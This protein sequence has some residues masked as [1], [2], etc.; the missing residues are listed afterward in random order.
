MTVSA[1]FQSCFLQP[2]GYVQSHL[3][4]SKGEEAPSERGLDFCSYSLLNKNQQGYF[5]KALKSLG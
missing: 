5:I 2:C 1:F 4:L 3:V